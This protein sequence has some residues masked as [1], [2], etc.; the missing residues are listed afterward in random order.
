MVSTISGPP[1]IFVLLGY[2]N[3]YCPPQH[4]LQKPDAA[5]TASIAFLF[6][7][8]RSCGGQNLSGSRLLRKRCAVSGQSHPS[9]AAINVPS[10]KRGP[11]ESPKGTSPQCDTFAN[12]KIL[13]SLSSSYSFAS[14]QTA[15]LRSP[16]DI[17]PS[18]M[19]CCDAIMHPNGVN[20]ISKSRNRSSQ[21]NLPLT[22]SIAKSPRS[23]PPAE[24]TGPLTH[25]GSET[26]R[27]GN[28]TCGQCLHLH[29]HTVPPH[30]YIHTIQLS[31]Q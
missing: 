4:Y 23:V 19:F 16:S 25:L 20:P 27:L 17:L 11:C 21:A 26:I 7:V 15:P 12:A 18:R 2:D 29:I 13:C 3:C 22:L 8:R 9:C 31:R 6:V 10:Q 24:P 1:V 5:S 14:S 28:H 30:R